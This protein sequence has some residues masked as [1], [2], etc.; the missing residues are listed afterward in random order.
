MGN[1]L[2]DQVIQ[3]GFCSGCGTCSGVCPMDCIRFGEASG[4]AE[5]ICMD[6]CINCNLCYKC[7]PSVEV[8]LPPFANDG[9]K[10]LGIGNYISLFKG[11][12]LDDFLRKNGASGGTVTGVLTYLLESHVVDR[13]I[14]ADFS[15][16]RSTYRIIA[17]S[18]ELINHQKSY[19][20]PLPV[21][22][23]LH[24][25]KSTD[26][27]YAIVGLPCQLEGLSKALEYDE[28]L[29][30]RIVVKLGLFCGY[31]QN[32]KGICRLAEYME[33][34]GDAWEFLGWRNGEYPGMVT[35]RNK[36][37]HEK[38]Q[39]PYYDSLNLLIPFYSL[40]KCFACMDSTNQ[41]ADIAFGDVHALGIDENI[42]IVRTETGANV[43]KSAAQSGYIGYSDETTNQNVVKAI[44]TVATAKGAAV[45]EFLRMMEKEGYRIP[46]WEVVTTE[47]RVNVITRHL[48]RRKGKMYAWSI[49]PKGQ[50][51]FSR[52]TNYEKMKLG[53]FIYQYPGSSRLYKFVLQAYK[54]VK[55]K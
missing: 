32:R 43:L 48:L 4:I 41:C 24:Q 44:Q 17:R 14:C 47:P 45:R 50:S 51:K 3:T 10:N 30:N 34:E 38:K 16:E 27:K 18:D 23:A 39:M 15:A 6:K 2:L 42:G 53:K 36:N 11:H 21:N 25:V 13:V 19:Y 20:V 46:V 52:L 22:I 26:L 7:C 9:V 54:A 37:T 49:S 33:C 29:K 8:K 31:A 28:R 55:R 12:A 40:K 35:F 5:D 1:K